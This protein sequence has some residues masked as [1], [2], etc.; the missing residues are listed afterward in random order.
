MA[1]YA[2]Q[3]AEYQRLRREGYS[4]PQASEMVWGPGG[5]QNIQKNQQKKAGRDGQAAAVGQV[6]GTAGGYYAVNKGYDYFFGPK[7]AGDAVAQGVSKG[8]E[9]VTNAGASAGGTVS[10][11]TPGSAAE[12]FSSTP[13]NNL[14]TPIKD[15][16]VPEG[17]TRVNVQSGADGSTTS[18]VVKSE[19]LAD[20]GFLD[21]VNWGKVAQGA[22]GA[23]QIAQAYQMYKGGDKGGAALMGAT[24]TANIAASGA[25]GSAAA[26]GA[27]SALGGY[28]VPGLNLAAGLYGGYQTAQAMGSMA[29]GSQ[30][31][32]AGAMGGA[33]SGAAIGSVIAPGIG[34][35]IGAAVGALA[36]ATASW[37]G[38]KKGKAQTMRDGIRN[39]LQEN[40]ILDQNYQGTLADGS[41][42]DFGKDGSTLKWKEI[43]KVANTNPN[44]W[45]PAVNLADALAV[46]YGF[47]GQKASDIA[48]WYA[49]AAVSNAGDDA[50]K[51]KQNVRHFAAQQGF[52]Y[53]MIK[54]KLDQAK[55]DNRLSDDQYNRYMAGA[56]DLFTGKATPGVTTPGSNPIQKSIPRPKAGEVARLSPGV[57]MD[58]KGRSVRG[59]TVRDALQAA[60]NKTKE[61]K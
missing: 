57:Y 23:L 47:V 52:T 48:A 49:K 27:S 41:K 31:T 39:V 12:M 11:S 10:G 6:A 42:Y 34:T 53:D 59:K 36:G 60:Y 55:A 32:K 1:S 33:A 44:A 2:E 43:D 22:G 28:L 9:A 54:Q 56:R 58:D 15:P 24:G 17:Y 29:G 14:Y 21:S 51:A 18:A 7:D 5:I 45:S 46:G 35:A 50:E 3:V 26:S 37:T 61:K 40:Q 38:S 8:T 19:M 4:G 25:M 16:S 20:K 30:R 13:T